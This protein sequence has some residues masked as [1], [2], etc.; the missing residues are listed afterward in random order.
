[1]GSPLSLGVSLQKEILSWE[2]RPL[3]SV[4]QNSQPIL[5]WHPRLRNDECTSSPHEQGIPTDS[6]G[7]S[8]T[9]TGTN[10][11]AEILGPVGMGSCLP[12]PGQNRACATNAP[13]SP[14]HIRCLSTKG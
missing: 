13:G 11:P 6:P 1:M 8:T 7:R 3:V 14:E 10:R 4:D 9:Y 5:V 2:E 12:T